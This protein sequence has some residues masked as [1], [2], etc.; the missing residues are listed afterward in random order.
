M[1]GGRK[2]GADT[3]GVKGSDLVIWRVAGRVERDEVREW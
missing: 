3:V 1:W 2:G